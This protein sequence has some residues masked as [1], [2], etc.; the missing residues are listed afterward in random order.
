MELKFL[1]ATGLKAED[2]KPAWTTRTGRRGGLAT[3]KTD[4]SKQVH[5]SNVTFSYFPPLGSEFLVRSTSAPS[6]L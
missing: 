3:E 2:L 1:G 4:K 6:L 5:I